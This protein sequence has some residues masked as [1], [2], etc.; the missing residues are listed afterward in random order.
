M[1]VT[2]SFIKEA[3]KL[4]AENSTKKVDWEAFSLGLDEVEQNWDGMDH[5]MN[6]KPTVHDPNDTRISVFDL[7]KIKDED[8]F[9]VH[10]ARFSF[11]IPS[12]SPPKRKCKLC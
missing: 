6:L 5:L 2:F 11:Y 9:G 10:D 1:D 8:L 4:V 12:V 7:S 3:D